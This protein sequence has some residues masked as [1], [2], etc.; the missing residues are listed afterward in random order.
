MV[1]SI[2]QLID[3]FQSKMNVGFRN[4]DMIYYV[5]SRGETQYEIIDVE[6]LTVKLIQIYEDGKFLKPILAWEFDVNSWE[7]FS[8]TPKYKW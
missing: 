8:K 6:G 5:H 7:G 2:R 3:V 4:G 1:V